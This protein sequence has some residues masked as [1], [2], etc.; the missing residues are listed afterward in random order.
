MAHF[1][2]LTVSRMVYNDITVLYAV[3][4]AYSN[5]IPVMKYACKMSGNQF[6]NDNDGDESDQLQNDDNINESD[7]QELMPRWMVCY[8]IIEA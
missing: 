1:D 6:E 8:E 5:I 3:Y 4:S 7:Q 2:T